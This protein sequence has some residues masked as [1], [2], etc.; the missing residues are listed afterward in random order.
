MLFS[1]GVFKE[2]FEDLHKDL[3]QTNRLADIDRQRESEQDN[4][5]EQTETDGQSYTVR[6]ID[7]QTDG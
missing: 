2:R 7:K 5:T 3:G 6:Q 1:Y 4:K